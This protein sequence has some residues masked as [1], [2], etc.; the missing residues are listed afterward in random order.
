MC[1]RFAAGFGWFLLNYK[2]SLGDDWFL[3]KENSKLPNTLLFPD[4]LVVACCCNSCQLLPFP[5]NKKLCLEL[6]P[7]G[8]KVAS[9][10]TLVLLGRFFSLENIPKFFP[11]SLWDRLKPLNTSTHI[12]KNTMKNLLPHLPSPLPSLLPTK[13][14]R[15]TLSQ[16]PEVSRLSNWRLAGRL[17]DLC[18][19]WWKGRI[20]WF[21]VWKSFG[22][23]GS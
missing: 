18:F 11:E 1:F 13:R 5:S 7:K 15:R 17:G 4:W 22:S 10:P 19:F 23:N 14:C 9:S 2:I 3:K 16:P 21:V 20:R 12:I 8:R 6:P